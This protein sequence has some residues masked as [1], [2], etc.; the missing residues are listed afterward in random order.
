VGQGSLVLLLF[1][2]ADATV[3]AWR[4]GDRHRARAVAGSAIFFML[5]SSFQAVSVFWGITEV[6]VVASL[7]SLLARP[8]QESEAGLHEIEERMRLAVESVVSVSG[9]VISHGTKSG[10]QKNGEDCSDLAR[11]KSWNS[12]LFCRG[13]TRKIAIHS[14]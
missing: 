11:R 12:T 13:C 1:F 7:A 2:V 9:F 4:R 14:G 10:R 6:P 3:T 5:F 8:L